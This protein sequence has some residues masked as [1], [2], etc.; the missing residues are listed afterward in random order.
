M[1]GKI[2]VL[3]VDD[4]TVFTGGLRQ[5]L[6]EKNYLVAIAN[7]MES[8]RDLTWSSRPDMVVLGT[9]MPRCDMFRFHQWLKHTLHL[10]E[11]PLLVINAHP[12]QQLTRGWRKEEGMQMEAEEFL[13]KPIGP[14]ALLPRIEKLLDRCTRRIN[15][16]IADDHPVV[17]DGIRAMLD[18]QKDMQVV[19]EAVNGHDALSKV[20]E[21]MPDVVLMDIVMPGMNGLEAS[22]QIC[23]EH[24]NVKVLMLTQYDDEEN[25]LAST[26]AGAVGFI[27][28]KSASSLLLEGI[29]AVDRGKNFI[30]S[31]SN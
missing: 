25:I 31:R 22:K 20:N 3:I 24:S 16:L 21:L 8:A 2:K 6:E 29:R 12:Q 14:E 1:Q 30:P 23:R 5:T 19:G 28:K 18:L 9:I 4:D 11:I 13:C 17:R 15:V 26:Q 27:P 7:S 10:C